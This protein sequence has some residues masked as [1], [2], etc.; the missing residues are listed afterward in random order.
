MLRPCSYTIPKLRHKRELH[1][2]CFWYR[3]VFSSLIQPLW[4]AVASIFHA[5]I[6]CTSL[7]YHTLEEKSYLSSIL[8]CWSLSV[9]GP[10]RRQA[11]LSLSDRFTL[12]SSK[13]QGVLWSLVWS[14]GVFHLG[15]ELFDSMLLSL[16][17]IS[18]VSRKGSVQ[19]RCRSCSL[20]FLVK[21]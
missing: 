14:K 3:K 8:S 17:G 4:G 18:R 19:V 6:S 16:T 11:Y 7:R 9:S 15:T 20:W 10:F 2:G 1:I 21:K 5:Q 12:C 13:P